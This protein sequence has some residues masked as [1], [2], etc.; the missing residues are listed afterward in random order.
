MRKNLE[1]MIQSCGTTLMELNNI[2][3]KYAEDANNLDITAQPT[4]STP[5]KLSLL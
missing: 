4:I 3:L 2:L 1:I 5:K